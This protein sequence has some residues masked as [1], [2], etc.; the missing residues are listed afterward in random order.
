MTEI[1]VA[2][3]ILRDISELPGVQYLTELLKGGTNVDLYKQV[4]KWLLKG[5][6]KIGIL[7]PSEINLYFKNKD[8]LIRRLVK[9]IVSQARTATKERAYHYLI[10]IISKSSN[11]NQIV[12]GAKFARTVIDLMNPHRLGED[13]N[14]SSLADFLLTGKNE[15]PSKLD[16][17]LTE[18]IICPDKIN[19]TVANEFAFNNEQLVYALSSIIERFEDSKTYREI[20]EQMEKLPE[21]DQIIYLL[22]ILPKDKIGEENWKIISNKLL[23]AAPECP[24]FK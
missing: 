6:Y 9:E 7:T 22:N 12:Q 24:I 11:V 10:D 16:K 20:H 4:F 2:Q 21:D 18:L 13:G 8:A 15:F 23:P 1:E 19:E 17:Y 3:S 5:E 14:V